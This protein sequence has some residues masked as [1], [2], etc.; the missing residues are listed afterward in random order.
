VGT[1]HRKDINVDG[2]WIKPAIPFTGD[3]TSQRWKKGREE[4]RTNGMKEEDVGKNVN[5]ILCFKKKG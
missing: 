3:G 4:E 2:V 1:T 5:E